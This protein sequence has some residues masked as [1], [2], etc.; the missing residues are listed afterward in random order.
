MLLHFDDEL[1]YA[2]PLAATRLRPFEN[3]N[4]SPTKENRPAP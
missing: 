4:L 2:G 1:D 3:R